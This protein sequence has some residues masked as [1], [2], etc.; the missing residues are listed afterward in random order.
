M[1]KSEAQIQKEIL[2][3]LRNLP[4]CRPFKIITAN[5]RGV[6]DIICCL[7]G[8]FICFEVKRTGA[9]PTQLQDAQ[10]E[11][12]IYAGGQV[13]IVTSLEEV[14]NIIERI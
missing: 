3:F 10:K 1:S 4:Q 12:I 14:K 7:K 6:P 11:R 9:K 13:Y 5:E 2:K 8:R